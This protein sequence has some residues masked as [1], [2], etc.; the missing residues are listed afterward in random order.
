[1]MPASPWIGSMSTATVFSSIA[2]SSAAASPYGTV[3]KPGRERTEVVA[4]VRVV[5]EADDRGRAAVE[6][7][8]RR[9]R[10]SRHPAATP[11]TR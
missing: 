4:R 10:C 5:A 1:M 11:F 7:A 3:R 6:V 2:A 9:R 8:G